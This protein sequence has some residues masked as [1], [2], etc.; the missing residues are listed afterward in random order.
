MAMGKCIGQNKTKYIRA[1]G[2]KMKWRVSDSINGSK[3]GNQK[4]S[5]N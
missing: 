5:W 1:I 4:S 2:R 3:K